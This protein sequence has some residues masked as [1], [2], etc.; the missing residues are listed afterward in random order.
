MYA[1]NACRHL[2]GAE[3]EVELL[4]ELLTSWTVLPQ[5]S[6][7]LFDSVREHGHRIKVL[8][9]KAALYLC[10]QGSGMLLGTE[11]ALH[12]P[13]YYDDPRDPGILSFR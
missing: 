2:A 5:S 3:T 11:G 13:L 4:I 7:D 8:L 6:P 12:I 10:C 1:R 9:V